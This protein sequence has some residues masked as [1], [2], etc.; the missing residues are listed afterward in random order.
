MC[1]WEYSAESGVTPPW[2]ASSPA[3]SIKINNQDPKLAVLDTAICTFVLLA[4][5]WYYHH[6][7]RAWH[8][9]GSG[10]PVTKLKFK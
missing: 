3:T 4:A 9:V 5:R 6:Q 7:A 2:Q 10:H 8:K 1:I